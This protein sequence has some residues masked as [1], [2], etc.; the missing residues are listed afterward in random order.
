MPSIDWTPGRG[1]RGRPVR[2]VLGIDQRQ[3][4][5]ILGVAAGV[6]VLLAGYTVLGG[7]G[8]GKSSV[9]QGTVR[10]SSG[11]GV[12][13]AD[14]QTPVKDKS[15]AVRAVK[16]SVQH[17]S[18][19]FA[20]GQQIVGGKGY[21][22]MQDYAKAFGDP[23]SPA[24]RFAKYRTDP[25]PE[26]DTSYITAFEQAASVLG[27]SKPLATWQKDMGA[28]QAD[29]AAWVTTAARYQQGDATQSAADAAAAQVSAA[30]AS[31]RADAAAVAS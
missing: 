22:S 12:K 14:P 21:G 7:F 25:N 18:D 23:A 26:A 9:F 15:G 11:S 24:A 6:M 16:D 20:A 5:I 8:G 3:G 30:L 17:Y 31:A 29:L 10:G 19:M 2:R 4:L 13:G 28:V 1:R 27:S